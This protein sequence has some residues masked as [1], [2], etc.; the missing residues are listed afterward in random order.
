MLVDPIDL[1]HAGLRSVHPRT[2]DPDEQLYVERIGRADGFVVVTPEYNHAYPAGLKHAI[3]L[4]RDEWRQKPVAFVSYGGLAGGLRAVE[5]LRLV[6]AELHATTVRDTVSFHNFYECFDDAGQPHDRTGTDGRRHHDARPARLV[7]HRPPHRPR[8]RPVR[9]RSRLTPPPTPP[10]PFLRADSSTS[11]EI[12]HA[13]HGR[14]RS[15][16]GADEV[17]GADDGEAGGEQRAAGSWRCP[18]RS[19]RRSAHR[20][21]SRRAGRGGSHRPMPRPRRF[22]TT[23]KPI[24]V[25]PPSPRPIVTSPRSSASTRTSTRVDWA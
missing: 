20:P 19:R 23:S 12:T 13:E 8:P 24:S 25:R 18:A 5:Q 3:D 9:R 4:P 2:L 7:G 16:G 11:E 22:S 21:A 1:A 14:G 15:A 6:F 10:R 17:L